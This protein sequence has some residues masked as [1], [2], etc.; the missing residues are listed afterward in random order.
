MGAQKSICEPIW[1][2]DLEEYDLWGG[3]EVREGSMEKIMP[4]LVS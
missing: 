3:Q 2:L 4:L 1:D